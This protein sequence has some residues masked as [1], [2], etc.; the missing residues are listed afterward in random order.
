MAQTDAVMLGEFSVLRRARIVRGVLYMSCS[1][2][3]FSDLERAFIL[4]RSLHL[5]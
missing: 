3:D 4:A 5:A 1:G 2:F